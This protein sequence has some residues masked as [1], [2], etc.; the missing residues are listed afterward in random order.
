MIRSA[1][2]LNRRVVL[3][4]SLALGGL[5]ASSLAWGD[6][7][8]AG[9]FRAG[10]LKSEFIYETAPFP[11]CHASTIAQTPAGL[12]VA[13][14]GGTREKNPDVEIWTSREVDG[15]WTAPQSVAS[16]KQPD[17]KRLPC[18]NPVLQQMPSGELHLF[19]KV[20]PSPDTW[21][22]MVK[23]SRDNGLTWSAESR[24]PDGF[25]GPVK[26]KPIL[27]PDGSL[28]CGSSTEHAGWH[29]H[30]E[31]VDSGLKTWKKILPAKNNIEAIQPTILTLSKD[32][33]LMLSRPGDVKKVVAS[34]SNDGGQTWSELKT[35][36]LPNP[37]SGIDGVTL[38]NGTHLL[39]YN[40]TPRG[41]SPLCLGF[42]KDGEH[43]QAA[44]LLETEP[45]EYSYPAI[46]QTDDGLVHITY[47]WKRKKVRHVI[48][49]PAK[50]Q[51]K[52]FDGDAWPK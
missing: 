47:T 2:S 1:I 31:H 6:D 4:G 5:A 18:W 13:W 14:F 45:G 39:V 32:K 15:K 19:Y 36:D 9:P 30:L 12:I 17:G 24:L 52:D 41:R 10:I 40:H 20:G 34:T 26:N 3:L 27:L 35:I 29:L 16:G 11:E 49:D 42:S 7:G 50:L 28:L 25:L 21:W 43:W 38:K 48:V 23:T 46:I 44:L 8:P 22:G 37:N 33:L 51:P